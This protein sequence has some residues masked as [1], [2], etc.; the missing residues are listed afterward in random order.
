M[1]EVEGWGVYVYQHKHGTAAEAGTVAQYN[2]QRQIHTQSGTLLAQQFL[3]YVIIIH[4]FIYL[5]LE[6]C[7]LAIAITLMAS[8]SST[9]LVLHANKK[10]ELDGE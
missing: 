1:G 10:Y 6:L 2:K 7:S 3:S 8:L 9:Q 5:N 4:L